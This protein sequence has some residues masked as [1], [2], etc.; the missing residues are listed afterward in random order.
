MKGVERRGGNGVKREMHAEGKPT[1]TRMA[2]QRVTK[3]EAHGYSTG[4]QRRQARAPDEI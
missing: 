1:V 3:K 4:N 2:T